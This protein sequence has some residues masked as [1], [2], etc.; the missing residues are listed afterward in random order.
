MKIDLGH[1]RRLLLLLGDITEQDADAI[2]N[3]ANSALSPGGGVC[4]AIHRAGGPEIAQ[5]CARI[6]GRQ[7]EVPPGHAV[8]TTA[9]T[10]QARHVIHA[11]GPRWRDGRSGEAEALA[12]C[13]RESLR[14]A[15]ELG[16]RSV[17]FPSISTGT[18]GHP[19]ELAAATALPVIVAA[20]QQA[21]H[22]REVRLVLFDAATLAAYER[23]ATVVADKLRPARR[24]RS[25]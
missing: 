5:E 14:V 1:G 15:D 6:V 18:F 24:R 25:G 16:L 10:L 23:E 9:G 4:G 17:A 22:V 7:G 11:V 12:G 13:Y 20:L 2:V 21:E 3:A 8:A 19:L